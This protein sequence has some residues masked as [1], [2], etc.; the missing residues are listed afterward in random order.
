ML[1][2]EHRPIVLGREFMPRGQMAFQHLLRLATKEAD[3]AILLNR[4]LDR[5]RRLRHFFFW[6]GWYLSEP[7][8][9]LTHRRDQSWQ[10]I[11]RYCTWLCEKA[12]RF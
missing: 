5:H 11:G 9:L 6:N 3:D 12:G 7:G 2:L 10:I 8:K 4:P 1:E